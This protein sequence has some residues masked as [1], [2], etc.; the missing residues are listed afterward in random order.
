MLF[1]K[2][3]VVQCCLRWDKMVS[4]GAMRHRITFQQMTSTLDAGGGRAISYSTFKTVHA[5]I[6]QDSGREKYEQGVLEA[7]K[8]FTFT[9]RFISGLTEDM[10]IIFNSKS[11]NITSI[12]NDDERNKYLIIKADEG[13]AT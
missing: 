6:K 1:M 3:S 5:H 10:R 8:V 4:I 9:I 7:K 11:F 12:I 2:E 13:V